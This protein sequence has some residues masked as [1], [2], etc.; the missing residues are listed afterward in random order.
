MLS[1]AWDALRGSEAPRRT[2][3]DR[4]FGKLARDVRHA[5]RPRRRFPLAAAVTLALAIGINIA[6]FSV[7]NTVLLEPI[8]LRTGW[9]CCGPRI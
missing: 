7:L 9:R 2:T 8:R 5:L 4:G 1:H 6:M 3:A